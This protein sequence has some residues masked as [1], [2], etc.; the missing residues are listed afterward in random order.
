MYLS[1]VST[2][3]WFH[4]GANPDDCGSGVDAS[5]NLYTHPG[6]NTWLNS[7]TQIDANGDADDAGGT[8]TAWIS[9]LWDERDYFNVLVPAGKY[10]SWNVTWD[11]TASVYTYIYKC[12]VQTAPCGL[13]AVYNPAYYVSQ[14]STYLGTGVAPTINHISGLWVTQGGWLTLGIYQIKCITGQYSSE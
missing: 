8:C 4:P 7:S 11:S 14:P 1:V 12:Q 10:L 13:G 9:D 5:D 3:P 6:G 2:E